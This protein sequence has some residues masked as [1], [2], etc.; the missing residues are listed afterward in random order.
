VQKV[1]D[2]PGQWSLLIY[3]LVLLAS[4]HFFPRGIMSGWG[5]L[6]RWLYERNPPER[7]E[8]P[9]PELRG[10]LEGVRLDL[11]SALEVRG[12]AKN[13]SGVQAL[14]GI[15]LTVAPGTIHALIG[16]NGS[17]KTT[18]LNV[19][20][21]FLEPDS[22]QVLLMGKDATQWSVNRR[23][24]IGLARTFQTPNIFEDM[25]CRDNVLTALDL[26]RE[27]SS[28][29]YVLRLPGAFREERQAYDRA[30]VLLHAVGLG[31]RITIPA[32]DLPPGERRLLELARLLALNPKVV[33]LDEPAGG[34]TAHEIG[35][36]GSAI[37]TLRDAGI[38]VLLVE[39]HV[40]FVLG[41]ADTVTVIDFGEVISRGAPEDIR[42][43]PAVLAA[44][45]GEPDEEPETT[46]AAADLPRSRLLTPGTYI[47]NPSD[48]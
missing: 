37:R 13:L 21:G 16:P 35:E 15:D 12:V 43:D 14:R 6:R 48:E 8:R 27:R 30:L 5:A 28:V 34:L 36:L 23:A 39:H 26:H 22:G 3:G 40:D 24:G 41:L 9:R 33:L 44:Y 42:N 18:L 29:G 25:T 38:A 4:V 2:N 32:G 47:S 17:G 46:T 11:P 45:L 1:T 7:S 31:E 10:V 19:M 20:S